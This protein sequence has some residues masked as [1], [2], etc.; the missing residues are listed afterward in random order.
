VVVTRGIL[1]ND[2]LGQLIEPT[3]TALAGFDETVVAALGVLSIEV[4]GECPGGELHP[5]R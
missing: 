4:P 5:I 3:L 2:D 1:V